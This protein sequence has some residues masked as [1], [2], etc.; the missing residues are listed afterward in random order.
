M[1]LDPGS[2]MDEAL[3]TTGGQE[4]SFLVAC[5]G[6]TPGAS[7]G[8]GE[9]GGGMVTPATPAPSWEGEGNVDWN[10]MER[11]GES[12]RNSR[13]FRICSEGTTGMLNGMLKDHGIL[14]ESL[15]HPRES[16]E[17]A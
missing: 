8:G 5:F 12:I 3:D 16:R 14:Q 4:T 7:D 17:I 11:A 9:G 2:L 10:S 1:T 6:V 15:W 13:A